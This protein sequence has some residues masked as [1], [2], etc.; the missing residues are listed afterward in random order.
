MLHNGIIKK[1]DYIALPTED[2][3]EWIRTTRESDGNLDNSHKEDGNQEDFQLDE[4]MFQEFD[5]ESNKN[6]ELEE[7]G[8]VGSIPM[9]AEVLL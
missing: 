4:D 1:N 2:L 3:R 9:P 6:N 5:E 8:P 7:Q